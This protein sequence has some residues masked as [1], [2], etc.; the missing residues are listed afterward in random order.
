MLKYIG[1][2]DNNKKKFNALYKFRSSIIHAGQKLKT[3]NLYNDLTK[4][5]KDKEFLNQVEILKLSRLSV[6][7]WLIINK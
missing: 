1:D 2:N 4:E 3:E 5:E 6:V 7:N